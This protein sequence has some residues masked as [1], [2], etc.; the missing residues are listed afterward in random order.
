VLIAQK[1]ALEL[2]ETDTLQIARRYPLPDRENS[3]P[4]QC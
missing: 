4:R 3:I 1:I 2:F